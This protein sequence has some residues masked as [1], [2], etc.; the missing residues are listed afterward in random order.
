MWLQWTHRHAMCARSFHRNVLMRTVWVRPHLAQGSSTGLLGSP[1]RYGTFGM[2]AAVHYSEFSW[3]VRTRRRIT[4]SAMSTRQTA[5]E[6]IVVA[7]IS[8]PPQCV[9]CL[10]GHWA[11]TDVRTW[12]N[13]H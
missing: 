7:F 2:A 4:Y 12:G 3:L 6:K 5:P 1:L 13:A 9:R 11:S 8:A 10:A